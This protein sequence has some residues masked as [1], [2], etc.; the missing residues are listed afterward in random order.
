MEDGCPEENLLI[1]W[2]H[3]SL[4]NSYRNNQ[5]LKTIDNWADPEGGGGGGAGDPDPPP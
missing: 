5:C 2:E 1:W 3:V 4:I